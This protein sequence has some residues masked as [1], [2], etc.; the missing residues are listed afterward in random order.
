MTQAQYRT[1]RRLYIDGYGLSWV[2]KHTGL[3][4]AEIHRAIRLRFEEHGPIL[5][6]AD[7]EWSR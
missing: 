2:S 4:L 3:T 5:L 6:I 1:A 7:T